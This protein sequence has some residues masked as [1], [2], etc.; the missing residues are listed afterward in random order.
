MKLTAHDFL[1]SVGSLTLVF[2]QGG[3]A[4]TSFADDSIEYVRGLEQQ[5]VA[6]RNQMDQMKVV[7]RIKT[8]KAAR[9]PVYEQISHEVTVWAKGRK[10]RA[11]E[12]R[13]FADDS[14]QLEQRVL[15]EDYFIDT[16]DERFPVELTQQ[17]DHPTQYALFHPRTLGTYATTTLT[18]DQHRV[19]EIFGRKDRQIQNVTKEQ[20]SSGDE[21]WKAVS[22]LTGA[23]STITTW[24]D[25]NKGPSVT[26]IV[27]AGAL[28][29]DELQITY[30]QYGSRR[31]WYPSK[32]SFQQWEGDKLIAHEETVT[33]S[34][35]FDSD[36]PDSIFRL[37]DLG[38]RQGRKVLVDGVRPCYWN[39]E[40]LVDQL[41]PSLPVATPAIQNRES[42][43]RPL[44]MALSAIFSLAMLVLI[45]RYVRRS[46]PISPG[47]TTS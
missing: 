37:R 26:R 4:P 21:Q 19:N 46:R 24:I 18:L 11:E 35:D 36:I 41:R 23:G 32:V 3:L 6:Y 13:E 42:G 29:Q 27:A 28:G 17:H 5:A 20:A 47:P 38:L 31:V 14:P 33:A 2:L 43:L 30:S 8:L 44:Y 22:V 45:Y 7:W 12:R 1:A 25:P 16:L 15:T 40:Q 39:G 9:Q 10:L 34:A